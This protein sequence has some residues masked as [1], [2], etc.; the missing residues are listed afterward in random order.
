MDKRNIKNT[1]Q[2]PEFAEPSPELKEYMTELEQSN[3]KTPPFAKF[4]YWIVDTGVVTVLKPNAVKLLIN[5]IRRA[6][7]VTNIGRI[8]NKRISKESKIYKSSVSRPF[9]DLKRL[10]VIK[11]W[12]KGWARYYQIQFSPPPDIEKRVEFYRRPDKCPRNTDIYHRDP[13]TGRFSKKENSPK[14]S[15]VAYPKNTEPA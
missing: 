13:K 14:N 4:P 5:L 1:E 12:R 2:G 8:G 7:W 3:K 9:K 11:I 10:G 15:D 6:H